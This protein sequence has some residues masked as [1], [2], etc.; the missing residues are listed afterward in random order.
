MK[1][2][3]ASAEIKGLVRKGC[4]PPA[5]FAC[6]HRR[7]IS[8][9]TGGRKQLA[10]FLLDDFVYSGENGINLHFGIYVRSLV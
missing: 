10:L 2:K 8:T 5:A 9:E 6:V 3:K 1:F 7:T 4:P